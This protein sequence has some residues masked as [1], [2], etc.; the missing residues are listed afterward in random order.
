VLLLGNQAAHARCVQISSF[1]KTVSVP[2]NRGKRH[3][4]G[5]KSIAT[6]FNFL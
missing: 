1:V 2:T 5:R 6:Q 4:N 3:A